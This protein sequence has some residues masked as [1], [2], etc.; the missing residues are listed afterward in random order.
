MVNS[1]LT[2]SQKAILT[3]LISILG[4]LSI[5]WLRQ[6]KPQITRP[7]EPEAM[8]VLV[9]A[10]RNSPVSLRVAQYYM[11]RRSIPHDHLFTLDL[12]DSSLYPSLESIDYSTYKNHVEKPIRDFLH[13]R[14]L[15]DRIRYL[16]L[17]RG[18]PFR[19]QEVP[20]HLAG[21]KYFT[22]TQSVDSTLAAL[23]YRIPPIEF[24]DIEFDEGKNPFG[25]LTPNLYWRQTY[26]FEHHL[27]GGYLVTRLDGYSE[28]DVR[29]LVDRALTPRPLLK[30]SVLIDPQS[31][32]ES[33]DEPQVIDIFDPKSC[34]PQVTPRCHPLSKGMMES[35]SR[36]YNND[37]RLST[38]FIK[39]SFPQLLVILAPP[40]TFATSRDLIGYASWGSND[41][42]FSLDSY[43]NLQ[44]L[45]GAVADS[46]VS[47]SGR[48]FFPIRRGGQSLIADLI[49]S[50]EG[51]TGVRGYTDEPELQGLGSPLILFSNYF[52]GA[53]LAT[54]YY[55]SIRFVG[56]RDLV[57][58][59]P[60]ATAVFNNGQ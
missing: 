31:D 58:G 51:V 10:N 25:T 13:R 47:S 14:G 55:R 34:N 20:S 30:G 35:F 23:D 1:T 43:R 42:F 18:I 11:E 40:N 8:R 36:D 17:T 16:V 52:K 7:S 5:L 3:A 44:F 27:T 4:F 9:I 26:P 38:Q 45:P 53:N 15:T 6:I 56:W 41:K 33:S 54:A 28:A 49:V 37:L 57:L 48:T 12:P 50:K 60:L 22:Q 39:T 32:N 29:A 24:K 59:D 46:A 2:R 19:V 21:G